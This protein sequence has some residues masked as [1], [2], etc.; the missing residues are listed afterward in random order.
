[1]VLSPTALAM[2]DGSILSRVINDKNQKERA[3][4]Q[5]PTPIGPAS[6]FQDHINL[7]NQAKKHTS[8]Q[9]HKSDKKHLLPPG[10]TGNIIDLTA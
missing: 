5:E 2:P 9:Y 3:K 1:M 10:G 7:K 8:H 6:S 4:V